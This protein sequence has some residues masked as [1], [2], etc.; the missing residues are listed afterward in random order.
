MRWALLIVLAGCGGA[1]V[2]ASVEVTSDPGPDAGEEPVVESSDPRVAQLRTMT[3]LLSI[4]TDEVETITGDNPVSSDR[5][6]QLADA[7]IAWGGAHYDAYETADAEGSF[8]G[9]TAGDADDPAIRVL[10]RELALVS[11]QLI[12]LVDEDCLYGS[13][14]YGDALYEYLIGFQGLAHWSSDGQPAIWDY[15]T[16]IAEAADS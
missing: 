4:L 9:L 6:D 7:V 14:S 1:S 13:G 10:A 2:R 15:E 3:D 16:L 12:E 5:C 8:L 11:T